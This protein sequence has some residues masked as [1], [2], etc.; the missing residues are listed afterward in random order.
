MSPPPRPRNPG[1]GTRTTGPQGGRRVEARW[2]LLETPRRSLGRCWGPRVF[3]GRHRRGRRAPVD[4][5]V[6]LFDSDDAYTPSDIL[7]SGPG[8]ARSPALTARSSRCEQGGPLPICLRARISPSGAR[9][10]HQFRDS[11]GGGGR[12]HTRCPLRSVADL[13]ATRKRRRHGRDRAIR[14]LEDRGA[15]PPGDHR[16]RPDVREQRGPRRADL[17]SQGGA[18]PRSTGNP[19]PSR[20]HPS[21][22]SKSTGLQSCCEQKSGTSAAG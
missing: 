5:V 19:A 3:G 4:D 13:H 20:A 15:R 10:W 12:R 18:R 9:V 6:R 2:L 1:P 21:P 8:K 17:L 11:L 14:L 22:S 7:T 16:S